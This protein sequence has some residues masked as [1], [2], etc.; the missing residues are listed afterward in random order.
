MAGQ[1]PEADPFDI[2]ARVLALAA[3]ALLAFFIGGGWVSDDFVHVIDWRAGEASHILFGAD[4]F[5]FYRP[6]AQFSLW[7]E[8]RAHGLE[9]V[10]FRALNVALHGGIWL[11]AYLV[12]RSLMTARAAALA[13]MAFVLAP[14][15]PTIAVLWIS[16][17]PELLMSACSLLAAWAWLRWHARGRWWIALAAGSYVIA[18]LAKESAALLPLALL[19][20]RPHASRRSR[21]ES[22]AAVATMLAL[23]IV[24]LWLRWQAGA[25]MPWS[26]DEHY[27]LDWSPYRLLRGLEVYVPRA[28]PSPVA[29]LIV[30]GVPAALASGQTVRAIAHVVPSLGRM[31]LIAISWFAALMLPVF[32]IPARSELY[33]YLPA[34]GFC[35]L[36]AYVVDRLLTIVTRPRR[37]LVALVAYGLALVSYQGS[38]HAHSLEVQQFTRGLAQSLTAD[39]WFRTHTGL[40]SLVAA[41][42]NSE[43]LMRD[44]VGGYI[45]GVLAIAVPGHQ[46]STTVIYSGGPPPGAGSQ[47]VSYAF[48]DGDV[49]LR[50]QSAH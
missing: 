5:G 7:L 16:A 18:L 47:I 39:P 19:A 23:A 22:V 9:P 38:R 12:A 49:T 8:A 41:D 28:L 33:L 10:L 13:A 15:A 36:A 3:V 24:P 42:A 34:F 2:A 30:V 25:L 6:I 27:S 40:V 26:V 1:P 14:K 45:S 31:G 20:M 43:E 46:L 17:R 35:L 32:P 4:Q 37:I 50:A 11:L 44:G 29:L 21:R 48:K